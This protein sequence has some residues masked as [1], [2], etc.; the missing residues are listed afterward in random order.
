MGDIAL[1]VLLVGIFNVSFH[2]TIGY[3]NYGEVSYCNWK[4]L[5][6]THK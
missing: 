1:K 5:F 3:D 6:Y 2:S 4:L